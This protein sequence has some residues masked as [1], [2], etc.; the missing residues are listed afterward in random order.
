MENNIIDSVQRWLQTMV[1]DLNLCPFAKREL[2]KN[3]I[4]FTVSDAT[5]E[6]QLLAA[7]QSELERL[8]VS[9]LIETTLLIHP[10]ILQDFYDYND[11]LNTADELLLSMKLDGIYQVAS[12]HP[13]YQFSDTAQD[14]VENYSNKSPYPILHLLREASLEHA[15]ASH[16]DTLE[17][18]DN[19]IAQLNKLG[20]GVMQ[21]LLQDCLLPRKD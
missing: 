14:D 20:S 9:D 4:R 19:N 17:I 12:F 5:T 18:P 15:I 11:F 3:R 1:I 21:A 10:Y 6:I 2:I 7:L 16:P 13:D 8:N